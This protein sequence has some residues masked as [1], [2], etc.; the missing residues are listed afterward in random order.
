MLGNINDLDPS[1]A[2]IDIKNLSEIDRVALDMLQ[3]LIKKVTTSYEAFAFYEVY[4]AIY[5]FCI[6][7]MSSFYLDIL[8]DR[9][10]TFGTDS[11]DRRAAQAVLCIILKTLTKLIAP[12]L[13]FTAEEI[14]THIPGA[15]EESVF[16]AEFPEVE[17]KYIIDEALKNKWF[18][19]AVIRDEVNKALEIKR[20]DKL[21]GNA[22]EAK[23]TI[24]VI[25]AVKA[26]L[27]EQG[28]F[29]PAL[30]IVSAVD[31]KGFSEA[32]DSAYSSGEV[33]NLA[34]LVEKADGSKCQRC[35]NRSIS[36]GQFSEHPELC[37][38]C[39]NVLNK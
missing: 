4:H 11:K 25:D 8:K 29:L 16:L 37:E 18:T 32:P 17:E 36:V 39:F 19:F 14:W 30:F 22:L 3:D 27:E 38:R 23:V 31:V 5:Q 28:D 1:E 34:V 35:W 7:D 9:L 6:I 33:E 26:M 10:Y 21:I 15:K 13:S 20:A 12:I 2:K 24:Y